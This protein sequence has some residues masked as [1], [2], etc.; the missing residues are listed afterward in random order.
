MINVQLRSLD[1]TA[2]F[3]NETVQAYARALG[4][5]VQRHDAGIAPGLDVAQAQ[6]QLDAAR[7]QVE[8]TLAQRALMEARDCG[9]ARCV[10]FDILPIKRNSSTSRFRRFHR[11]PQQP[12]CS[13]A[14]IS[15]A[16]SGA[17]DGGPMPTSGSLRAAYFPTLTL[18][19]SGRL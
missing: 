14:R 16:R 3:L 6:T 4:L 17:H 7:S 5:T 19:R 8:Q 15:R 18:G 11:R 9:A 1:R 10:S 12:W 13:G 2:Q